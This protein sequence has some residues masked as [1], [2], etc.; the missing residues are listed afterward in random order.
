[1]VALPPLT[2]GSP[3]PTPDVHPDLTTIFSSDS[4]VLY[5]PEFPSGEYWKRLHNKEINEL[6]VKQTN[7]RTE[8][9]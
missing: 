8:Y 3:I 4:S 1:M 6:K 2:M 5:V 9:I 7:T